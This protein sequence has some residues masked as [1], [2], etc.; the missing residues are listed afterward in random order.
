MQSELTGPELRVEAAVEED[1][2]AAVQHQ[3][4]VAEAAQDHR[5][6]GERSEGERE[7]HTQMD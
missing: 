1:V 3:E 2:A 6:H 7:R 5:P 4:E